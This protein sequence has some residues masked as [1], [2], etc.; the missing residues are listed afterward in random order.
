MSK[1][2]IAALV[3]LATAAW[4]GA[5]GAARADNPTGSITVHKQI[6]GGGSLSGWEFA[7]ASSQCGVT[8]TGVTSATGEI[9]FDQLPFNVDGSDCLYD[10]TET[11]VDGYTQVTPAEDLRDL[12]PG[13]LVTPTSTNAAVTAVSGTFT[14]VSRDPETGGNTLNILCLTGVGTSM[15]RAGAAPVTHVCNDVS[16]RSGLGFAGSTTSSLPTGDFVVGTLTHYNQTIERGFHNADLAIAITIADNETGQTQTVTM[17][18]TIHIDETSDT[19]NPCKYETEAGSLNHTLPLGYGCADQLTIT[20]PAAATVA[21][22]NASVNLQLGF[23]TLDSS[24]NCSDPVAVTY[25][26]ERR[27]TPLCLIAQTT[28]TPY[29]GPGTDVTVTNRADPTQATAAPSTTFGT[30]APSTA[31]SAPSSA[32]NESSAPT[33][34]EPTSKKS[35]GA[36]ADTG[37]SDALTGLFAFGLLAAVLGAGGTLIARRR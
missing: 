37:S 14:G 29:A 7:L 19:A 25:T 11:A 4:A 27:N 13:T 6:V 9:V 3:L 24:G 15:V 23:G 31:S 10:L 5:T 2:W 22:K 1:R 35:G 28:I 20:Q 36:L 18:Y 33:A 16:T 17:T 34:T 26:A 21:L 30:A 12:T 32:A 8:R